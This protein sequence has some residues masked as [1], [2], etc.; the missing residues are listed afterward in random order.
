MFGIYK[1]NLYDYVRFRGHFELI[2]EKQEKAFPEFAKRSDYWVKVTDKTDSDLTDIFDV[3][4]WVEHH[5]GFEGF[6]TE[7]NFGLDGYDVVDGKI[8][9]ETSKG[10]DK[11]R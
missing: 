5:T 2:T 10:Y 6:P 7:W 1:N 8:V 3:Q 9:I 11:G 4:L